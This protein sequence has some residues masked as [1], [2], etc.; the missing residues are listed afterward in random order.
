MASSGYG[1]VPSGGS[2]PTD[3][4]VDDDTTEFWS[5]AKCKRAYID[6]IGSKNE[7]IEEQKNALAVP[8]WS[9]MDYDTGRDLRS[10][11]TASCDI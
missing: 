6:Y 11:Q 1:G 5:L 10:A 9:P 8:S 7:E 4:S 2:I 3:L